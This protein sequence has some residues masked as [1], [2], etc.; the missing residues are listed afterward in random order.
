MIDSSLHLRQA[1][2]AAGIVGTWYWQI[3]DNGVV[4]DHGSAELLTGNA[5][6]AGQVLDLDAS[7][8]CLHPDDRERVLAQV[9]EHERRGGTNVMA[10]RVR[11]PEGRVRTLL[12]RGQ[13]VEGSNGA[14]TGY[15]VLLDIT[16]RLPPG[17]GAL[18]DVADRCL[19][20]RDVLLR[21][22]TP[23]MQLLLDLLLLEIG[24]ELAAPGPHANAARLQ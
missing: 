23:K 1:L 8:A 10:Y 7:F 11:S 19:G 17:T 3:A 15:G 24:I 2:F 18:A 12:D 5:D 21:H 16:D 4:L 22:G 13:V 20:M 6:L 14:R 9:D